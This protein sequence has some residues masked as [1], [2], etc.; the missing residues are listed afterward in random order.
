LQR[1]VRRRAE[2]IESMAVDAAQ[3]AAPQCHAMT[4]EEFKNLNGDLA[5]VIEPVAKR[6]GSELNSLAP[7]RFRTL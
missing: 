4:I 7:D 1:L 5:T 6:G 3:I 2:K